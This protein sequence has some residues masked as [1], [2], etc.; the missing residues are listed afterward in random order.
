[1][2][3]LSWG[4]MGKAKNKGGLGFRGF[5]VFNKA[6][7][8]KQCWRMLSDNESLLSIVFKSRYFPRSDFMESKIGF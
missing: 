1:M 7:L 4:R 6:L 2:H 3:W 5:S 8:S